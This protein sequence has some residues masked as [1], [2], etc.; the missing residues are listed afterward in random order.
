M[1]VPT[2][3]VRVHPIERLRY[4]ARSAGAPQDVLVSE[5]ATALAAFRHD[6]SGLVTA[7]R[8]VVSRQVTAGA[9]WWLCSRMLCAPEPMAEA[10]AAVDE[11][12]SDPTA[13][14][15]AG[16]LPSD[17]TV[18]I[19]G[20]PSQ[21]VP[22]LARRGD[23]DVLVGDGAGEGHSLAAHLEHRDVDADVVPMSGL[24]S[25]AAA[26]DLVLL[27]AAAVG[28]DRF[29]ASAGSW[30]AAAVARTAAVPT[31]LV[32]GVG[33]VLPARVIE[34]IA[35]RLDE[36]ADPWELDD[37]LVPLALVDR[38]VGPAGLES[39]SDTLRRCDCP[40]APELFRADIT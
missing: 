20:W 37:E 23:L 19:V 30:S 25:A 9:L 22:A 3:V 13:R 38:V 33:R 10:R 4:V 12:E 15:L 14:A 8:R 24:A 2:N 32:A 6:P 35:G 16:A 39:P 40:I 7:C 31:W 17:A 34:V 36:M 11:I 5:T 27:D 28:P 29:V 1:A 21:I 26:A 18:L